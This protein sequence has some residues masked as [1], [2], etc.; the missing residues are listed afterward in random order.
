M[1]HY[2]IG[3]NSKEIIINP[4]FLDTFSQFTDPALWVKNREQSFAGSCALSCSWVFA[5]SLSLVTLSLQLVPIFKMQFLS[6]GFPPTQEHL[7]YDLR[8][9]WEHISGFSHWN[10]LFFMPLVSALGV[11]N[12]QGCILFISLILAQGLQRGD[13][14]KKL[15]N[16]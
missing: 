16:G 13:P 8:V 1:R 4:S 12:E 15:P 14:R 3:R 9:A 7:L 10:C 5:C 11:A 6:N 2:Y